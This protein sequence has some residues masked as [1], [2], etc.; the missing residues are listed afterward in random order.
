MQLRV[1]FL[2]HG[3]PRFSRRAARAEQWLLLPACAIGAIGLMVVH[4]D[5][6]PAA[7]LVELEAAQASLRMGVADDQVQQE[8]RP[9]R[10]SRQCS[11][12]P[13]TLECSLSTPEAG[14]S[15]WHSTF[16]FFGLFLQHDGL[17]P[18]INLS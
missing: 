10:N 15:T 8:I 3:R 17:Y 2:N 6:L 11:Q 14:E 9:I 16:S 7:V 4:H 13:S 18:F 12:K 5:S 1:G